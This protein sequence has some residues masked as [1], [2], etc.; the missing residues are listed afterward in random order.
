MIEL[1]KTT[2]DEIK[3]YYIFLINRPT[4]PIDII[5]W[6]NKNR[7]VFLTRFNW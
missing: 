5:K 3:S 2:Y 7:L 1:Y 4:N 6:K